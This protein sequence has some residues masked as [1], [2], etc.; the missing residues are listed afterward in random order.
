[1]R[2]NIL[3]TGASSGLGEEMARQFAAKGRNL[4]LCA[5]RTDALDRLR[6]ELVQAH[7]GI[8]VSTARLDVND[9][10]AVFTVFHAFADELGTLDR[11]IVNAGLGKGQPIGTGSFYAN[12][13]TAETN[14]LGALAQCEAAME[15]FRVQ[16]A[17]HLVLV[18]SVSALRGFPGN[19]TTYAA[20]K[21]AVSSLAEGIRAD[22][23]HTPI[24]VTTLLPG[25]IRSEMNENLRA[26]LIVNT[27]K[28]VRSM[29]HAMEREVATAYVP[30]WPWSV[31]APVLK[32]LP[33][34]ALARQR[35]S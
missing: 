17:G 10:D 24:A 22:V 34:R 18:S 4:A 21:A 33:L 9:H 35:Q 16:N 12:K 25:Y 32:V 3:I 5:R 7:P 19:V 8:T 27:D 26:P 15:I 1:M 13:Q 28:G 31:L 14:F 2:K 30:R 11:V 6:E 23:L 29:V 20:T